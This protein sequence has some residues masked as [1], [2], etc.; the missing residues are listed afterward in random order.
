M[1]WWAFMF[2]IIT[3]I[4]HAQKEANIWYFGENAGLDFNS[5]SPVVLVD[6]KLNTHEGC[7]SIADT[8]GNL[9]FYTDGITV[10]NKSHQVML[11][12]TGLLGHPSSSSSA[13]I[14]PKPQSSNIYYIFTVDAEAGSNGLQYSEVDMLLDGGLGG[15]TTYKNILLRTPATEK[16]TAV[17]KSGSQGYWVVSHNFNNNEFLAYS[18]S[19]MGVN[20]SP[21][22]SPVG[23]NI[24]FGYTKGC[25]KISPNGKRL[26]AANSGLN[27]QLFDFD[28][29]TGV[30]SNPITLTIT[31]DIDAYGVEFSPNNNVLY[32]STAIG[33][34]DVYQFDLNAGSEIDIV[35]SRIEITNDIALYGQLQL[36]TDG[37]IYVAETDTKSV[38]V[39]NNPDV[40]GLGCNY[41]TDA[42]NLLT[43]KCALGLPP[44]I[45]SFFRISNIQFEN[46]CFGNMTKFSLN[47]IVDSVVWDFGDPASGVTNTSTDFEPTHI[48]SSPGTY[49][50]SVTATLGIQKATDFIRVTIY[51]Q[52]ISYKPNDFLACDADNDGFYSFD[53]T[54]LDIAILSGQNPAIFE[55]VY[56]AS[57]LDYTNNETIVDPTNYSNQSAYAL[58]TIIA[59]VKN[60]NNNEC[61]DITTFNIQAFETH[62][63]S[64][65]I[66]KL[67]F[68]DNTS[69]G[70]DTDG[71]IQFDLTQKE[72]DILNGQPAT[73]FKVRYFTDASFTDE[74][75]SP[76]SYVNINASQTIYIQ[77]INKANLT[78]ITS[79]QFIIEVFELPITATTVDLK[80]CD[81]DLDGFSVFNLNESAL[82]ITTNA[83]NETITFYETLAEA[84][85]GNNPIINTT[86]YTN[87]DVSTDVI[88]ARI[89]NNN[90]CFRTAQVNLIVSTTQIPSSFTRDF[91]ECDDDLDGDSFNGISAFDFSGL[92]GEIENLFPSGQQLTINYYRNQT[93]ALAEHNPILD[94]S[95]YRN[96]G[97][98]H[99]QDVY[100][101]VD[102]AIDNDCL[103]LGHHI[104]LHVEKQPIAYSV[105]IQEQCDDD[106]DT[107]YAFDTTTTEAILLKGQTG[108]TVSYIDETG[109]LLSSPLPNPFLT[110]SQTI[111]ARVTNATS[112]DPNGACFDE[113]NIVF[114]VDAAA[115]AHGVDD[116]IECDDD[117]DGQFSFDTS[118]I[119][120]S[121]L[122]GQTGMVVTYID[123][124]GHTLPSP[125]PN[126]YLSESQEI[127]VL[128]ENLLSNICFD[129]TTFK[130]VVIEQPILNMNDTWLICEGDSVD[131]VA[132]QGYDEY[133][134]STEEGSSTVTVY[135][136]GTYEVTATN[137]YEN[138][139]CETSKTVTV[140]ESNVATITNIETKDWTQNDNVIL[141]F[142]EGLGDYEYSIDGIIYQEENTFQDLKINNYTIY[143]R[144][145]KG[146]GI[147]TEEVF[148][149]Y[150]P[151]YFTPN[152]DGLHD[153]WHIYNSNLEPNNKI[154]IYN[155]Y[156]KLIK[157][158]NPNN[159]GW[160]GTMNGEMMPTSDYWFVVYRQNGKQY[161]GHFT[162]KR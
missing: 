41:V 103:G 81:D 129:E 99:T 158:L 114:N 84:S 161:R 72:S 124:S 15:I 97:Y 115:V 57:M 47:D 102:S 6:G 133:L 14:V 12:G 148:L 29:T 151:K 63:P 126:P 92:N 153:T 68:C 69:V 74:I 154:Y 54:Q 5:G 150:Y 157:Q 73:A 44:F 22:I 94:I 123:E 90:Q 67:V 146:C 95:N 17:R 40:V 42:V 60:K 79:T 82:K 70:T 145:K 156:G 85:S 101:R 80:Q 149:V 38:G 111:T 138:I 34:H 4:G 110:S 65:T 141:V 11:N 20:T 122:N 24:P 23:V 139:R 66:S 13:I 159:I 140:I 136:A 62:I 35:N 142:V 96:E 45:Q 89:E 49:D 16:I 137:I 55:V 58:E 119:E 147:E 71:I 53:L 43:G 104:T 83:S 98:P 107:M 87:E 88:W 131:I 31:H 128:V 105:N 46:V 93:D 112:Q 10:W 109:N 56:Y 61:S 7:A 86:T 155:R 3:S 30:V 135:E 50:V 125:L 118:N 37:K 121:I 51:D 8:N 64:Q 25:I 76:N 9:L 2:F 39:I 160:D 108:M 113:T 28:T 52:P 32:L 100:I 152:N 59:A 117:G 132:D 134:W 91:Y 162:L 27:T 78:C 36:A 26:V 127:T 116:I 143:I 144:D 106:G 21:V 77:V 19:N 130:L 75:L 48:F 1:K 33:Y 120:S 18:V